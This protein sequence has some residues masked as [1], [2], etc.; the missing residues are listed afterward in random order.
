MKRDVDSE[1]SSS[2]GGRDGAWGAVTTASK[3]P[4]TLPSGMLATLRYASANILLVLGAG[5]LLVGGWAP[6]VVLAVAL[7]FGSFADEIIGDDDTSLKESRCLF[8]NINLY[9]SLPLVTL[10]AL[11]LIRFAGERPSLTDNLFE[12]CGWSVISSRWSAPPSPMS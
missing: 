12:R 11:L 10:L 3:S 7:V 1:F 2:D 5:A 9:L 4:S 8:C 6:W